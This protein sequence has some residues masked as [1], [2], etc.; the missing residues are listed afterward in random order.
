MLE[1]EKLT[2]KKFEDLYIVAAGILPAILENLIFKYARELTNNLYNGGL[3]E[4][5]NI[6]DTNIWFYSLQVNDKKYLVDNQYTQSK[7]EISNKCLSLISM[8]FG[9]SHFMESCYEKFNSKFEEEI[10]NLFYG[11]KR[12]ANLVLDKRELE[13]FYQVID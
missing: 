8:I 6:K 4:S 3:W 5:E 11:I 7:S 13:I 9:L 2:T 12:N 1:N 10:Y